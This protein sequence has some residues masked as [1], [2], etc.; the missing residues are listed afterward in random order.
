MGIYSTYLLPAHTYYLFLSATFSRCEGSR[1]VT[2]SQ[3]PCGGVTGPRSRAARAD[4]G[5]VTR[6]HIITVL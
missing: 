4:S 2:E 1:S 6:L 3:R 5:P